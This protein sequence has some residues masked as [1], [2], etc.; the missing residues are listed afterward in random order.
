MLTDLG[1]YTGPI[2][3]IYSQA[4]VDAVKAL[5]AQLGVPQTGII[6]AATLKAAYEQ[7]LQAGTP[8][9]TTSTPPAT[10]VAPTTVPPTTAVPPTTVLPPVDPSSPTILGA[11]KA[12]ARFSKF[13]D[14]LTKA[15]YTD[16]TSVIGP[17]T[18]FAPTNDAIDAM[19]PAVL[20]KLQGNPDA[21]S[22]LLSFHLVDAGI[23]LSFLG[24]LTSVPTMYGEPLTV[25]K[26][27]DVVQVNGANTIA[28]DIRA[29]NGII[30]PIDAVLIPTTQPN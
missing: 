4:V 29:S 7:G 2:D 27:G 12:D 19:D 21:M 9:P 25:T 15:G 13:V 26:A 18:V 17:I 5:Q 23:T 6:D 14:F 8:P 16:D 10:T 1:F 24:S 22:Q 3:G 11:L 28:P 30:I 20:D